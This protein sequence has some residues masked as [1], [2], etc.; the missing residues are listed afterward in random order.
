MSIFSLAR[1]DF[2][3]QTKNK[4]VNVKKEQTELL[5]KVPVPTN[6][7]VFERWETDFRSKAE[8][9]NVRMYILLQ[10]LSQL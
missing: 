6:E 1:S 3:Q 9:N 10:I 2:S 7:I 5:K 4:I 8:G